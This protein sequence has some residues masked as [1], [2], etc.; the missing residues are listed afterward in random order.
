MYA[1]GEERD[2]MLLD[3]EEILIE[4]DCAGI[5]VHELADTCMIN[6]RVVNWDKTGFAGW[7]FGY[8]D[9]KK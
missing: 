2:Q 5:M 3:A 6:E 9:I 4:E 8:T 1:T 7:Y